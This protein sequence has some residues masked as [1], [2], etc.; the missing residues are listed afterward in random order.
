MHTVTALNRRKNGKQP[1]NNCKKG[2]AQ[3]DKSPPVRRNT[4]YMFVYKFM[5]IYVC[6]LHMCVCVHVYVL[7]V[8]LFVLSGPDRW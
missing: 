7:C 3:V 5:S 6:I 2:F 8:V 4:L 1:D